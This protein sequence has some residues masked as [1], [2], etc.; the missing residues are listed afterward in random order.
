MVMSTGNSNQPS[1]GG[2]TDI[3]ADGP[4]IA[5]LGIIRQEK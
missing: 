2:G 4:D 1:Y 5:S 3:F